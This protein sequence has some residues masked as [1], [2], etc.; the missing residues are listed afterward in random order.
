MYVYY[1]VLSIDSLDI[2]VSLSGDLAYSTKSKSIP[3]NVSFTDTSN[4][5]NK[6]EISSGETK[7]DDLYSHDAKANYSIG[8][9]KVDIKTENY[10]SISNAEDDE[11]PSGV[12]KADLI[13]EVKTGE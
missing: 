12:Y 3:W 10:E 13:I 6:V 4:S 9:F 7:E 2:L 8:V 11:I 5:A 1:K